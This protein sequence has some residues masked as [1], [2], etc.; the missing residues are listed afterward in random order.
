MKHFS[1]KTVLHFVHL[2]FQ[3]ISNA[4]KC[5]ITA[6]GTTLME[7]LFTAFPLKHTWIPLNN[8]TVYND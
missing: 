2:I 5:P 8:L 6:C 4:L 7:H 1:N 3:Y